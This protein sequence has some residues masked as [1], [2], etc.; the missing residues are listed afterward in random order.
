MEKTYVTNEGFEKLRS[1]LEYLKTTRRREIAKQL[2]YARSFG[3]LREN[4]EYEAAKHALQLNE[5]R[6]NELEMKVSNAEIISKDSVVT[7][8]VV[9]GTKVLL[10]DFDFDEEVEYEIT[11]TEEADPSTG[12]ISVNS[13][14]ASALLGHGVGEQ[15][16]VKAPRGSM[17]FEIKKISR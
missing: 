11:G 2:D 16:E 17:K 12:K 7:D 9:I 6:I 1:E 15:I 13:P 3:D 5:I 4:A 14:V 8:K 10:W